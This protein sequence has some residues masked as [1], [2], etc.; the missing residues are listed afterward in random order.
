MTPSP[1]FDLLTHLRDTLADLD[2]IVT[3]RI[4]LEPNIT[5]DQYPLIR[6]VPSRLAPVADVGQ[7]VRIDLIVYFGLPTQETADGLE[8]VYENLLRMETEIREA[9]LFA[10]V[11]AAGGRRLRVRAVETLFDEDRLPHYKLMASRFEVE[12]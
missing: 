1:P 9:V 6:I 10:T 7:R 12:G 11:R 3:C 2:G 8:A 5:P 4:G